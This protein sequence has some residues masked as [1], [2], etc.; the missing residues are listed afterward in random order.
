MQEPNHCTRAICPERYGL[1]VGTALPHVL[2]S[3]LM[4]VAGVKS[5]M[6]FIAARAH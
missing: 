5:A 3:L 1:A 2:G 6:F 4:T